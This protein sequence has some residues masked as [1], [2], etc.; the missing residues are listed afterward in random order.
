MRRRLLVLCLLSMVGILPAAA[1]AATDERSE[2]LALK[3]VAASSSTVPQ[4]EMLEL[5]VALG[6]TYTNPYNPDEVALDAVFTAPSG[7]VVTLPG[8][9]MLP[10]ERKVAEGV[11][12][13]TAGGDGSWRVRFAPQETGRYTWQLKLRDRSGEVSGGE[14]EFTA[15]AAV[16]PGFVRQSKADPHYLA[17]DNGEGCFLIGHNLPIYHSKGQLGDAAMHKFADAREN[18]N[19]WWMCSY[20]FGIEGQKQ[21]GS[22]RQDSAARID[23]VLEVA[24]ERGLYYMMCMDTHQDFREQGWAKNPFNAANGGPCAS[25]ADWFTN[26]TA[27]TLYKKRLRYTVARWGYSTNVLCWEFGNEFEGWADSPQAVMLPWHKEMSDYLRGLDPFRHLISTSF[28]GKT[29]PEAFWALENIDIVQTHCYMNNDDNV[30][31]PVQRYCL[32]QWERFAKPHIFGEFGIRSHVSTAEKDPDGR[33]IHNSLWAGLFSFAA[34]GPMPWWHENYIEPHNLYFHFTALANYTAGLPLGTAR[35]ERLETSRPEYADPQHPVQIADAV[36]VPQERWG[37]AEHQEFVLLPDGTIAEGRRPQ[38]LLHGSGH[39]DLRQPPTFVVDYRTPGKFLLHVDTVS[40]AG[41]LRVWLDDQLVLE[42]D[43][44]CA[45]GLGRKSVFRPQWKIWETTYDEDIAID[46]PA[47]KHRIRL[48]N[49]GRDWVRITRYVMTGCKTIDRPQVLV[50]GMKTDRLAM[51]W[52]QNEASS[53]VNHA[54]GEVPTEAAFTL[55]LEGLPDGKRRLEWWE[56]WKGSVARVEEAEVRNGQLTLAV[57]ELKTD[58]AVKI[59]SP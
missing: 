1:M 53:W 20:G 52:L 22:Y 33:A 43:L 42:R 40:N 46:V 50:C 16:R 24:R 13:M 55:T 32:H 21:L 31:E 28:W 19:R 12:E 38:A 5:T 34:G 9:W 56:T 6:A 25:P 27:R 23:L 45:E 37:Q 4:F 2:P 30:A 57:P 41:Q 18:F 51:V 26:E 29:G 59:L 54:K 49:L 58:V 14:G 3:E 17:F 7:R 11:E 15:T 39:G 47:G 36:V 35:W 10:C 8:F 44:P 48:D